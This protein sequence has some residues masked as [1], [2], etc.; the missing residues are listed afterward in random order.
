MCVM[1]QHISVLMGPPHVV[2]HC[3]LSAWGFL[4]DTV[5][6]FC[7]FILVCM[8]QLWYDDKGTIIKCVTNRGGSM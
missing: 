8:I 2:I 1:P 3:I 4:S 7:R 5:L 6:V